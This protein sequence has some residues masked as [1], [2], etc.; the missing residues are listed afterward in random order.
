MIGS[1]DELTAQEAADLLNVP[2]PFL[3][4]MLDEGAISSQRLGT[5]LR[6]RLA[7]VL[8]YRAERGRL[9]WA[10]LAEMAREA[11]ELGLYA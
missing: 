11:Q 2:L 3:V 4:R 5:D 7:D 10:V 6:V 9:R 1:P 8:A